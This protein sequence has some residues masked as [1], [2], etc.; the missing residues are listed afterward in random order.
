MLVYS[1]NP[2]YTGDVETRIIQ[3]TTDYDLPVV[4][5]DPN[6]ITE[7]DEELLA[8]LARHAP[9]TKFKRGDLA[10]L[11]GEIP[12]KV[13]MDF[14]RIPRVWEVRFVLSRWTMEAMLALQARP[15]IEG[16]DHLT[17]ILEHQG[18]PQRWDY[19]QAVLYCHGYPHGTYPNSVAFLREWNL[20]RL[21]MRD[22]IQP[23]KVIVNE[24]GAQFN[25][26][27]TSTLVRP[28]HLE[29]AP[30]QYRAG[31]DVGHPFSWEDSNVNVL[32]VSGLEEMLFDPIVP[33][34]RK[35]KVKKID[36]D[37]DLFSK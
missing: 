32:C 26:Y 36:P 14:E 12:Q 35:R 2:Y 21:T 30:D 8:A 10:M 24:A 4:L 31:N 6:S 15:D 3:P 1:K 27:D 19:E 25:G 11:K 28:F 17:A 20:Q 37:H 5:I 9:A 34:G 7:Q 22:P 29:L 16:I 23:W 18:G 33:G 13:K